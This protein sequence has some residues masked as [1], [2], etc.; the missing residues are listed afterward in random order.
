MASIST[1]MK[2][3]N[4]KMNN[5]DTHRNNKHVKGTTVVSF[6]R[7]NKRVKRMTSAR[8]EQQLFLS[9]GMVSVRKE[10]QLFLSKGMV[11][12][13]KEQQLFLSKGNSKCAKGNDSYNRGRHLFFFFFNHLK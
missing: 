9:K 7:N 11:S 8:K 2:E 1:I 3:R 5:N 4:G 10:Q 6:K 12:V 13:R